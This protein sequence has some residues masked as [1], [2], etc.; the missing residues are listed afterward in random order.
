[1][2]RF[3]ELEVWN[4]AVDFANLVYD[5]TR[6]FPTEERFGLTSQMRRAAVSVSA[7][8]A[9]GR[10]RRSDIDF[11]RFVEVAYG[12]LMEVVSHAYVAK[13]QNLLDQSEFEPIYDHSE[14]LAKMLSGRRSS[15][16]PR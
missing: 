1:M 15:L 5:A 16:I 3:E 4:L 6:S 9:E 2:F 7:N 8:V 11:A 13:R 12:S 14:Q 10:S